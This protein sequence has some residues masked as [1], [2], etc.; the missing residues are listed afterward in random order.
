MW[1]FFYPL[2]YSLLTY[3]FLFRQP[4]NEPVKKLDYNLT[5]VHLI[6]HW[7]DCKMF[8]YIYMSFIHENFYK[9]RILNCKTK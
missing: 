8:F 3:F 1:D 7:R 6:V 5:S 4:G 9:T 2:Y